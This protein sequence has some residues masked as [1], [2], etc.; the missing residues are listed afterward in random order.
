[1]LG[2]RVLV[3]AA[4][5]LATTSFAYKVAGQAH[6][7]ESF[8]A[9]GDG[10][11]AQG[12]PPTLVGR[13]WIFRNQSNPIGVS[14]YW[15]EFG[16]EWGHSGSALGHGGFSFWQ[17]NTSRLSAWI[18]LPAIPNQ[19][20]GDPL[21]FWTSAPTN[22][23]GT[24]NCSLEVRYSPSGGTSTGSGPTGIG[25]FTQLLATI[26]GTG[27]HA[28]TE[29][30]Y[31]LPGSGRIAI[32]M[33]LGPYPMSFP[34]TGSF[35]I[36]TLRVGNPPPPPYPIPQ[37]GETVR[38]TISHSPVALTRDATGQ[39][40]RIPAGATLIVDPGV[41]VRI[42]S[43]TQ[44]EIAGSVQLTGSMGQNVLIRGTGSVRVLRDGLLTGTFAD[45]QSFTDLVYGA[46][47]SF[48]DSAFSD[49]SHPT[50]F[51]YDSAGDIGHRF[52]DGNLD[53]ARQVLS[54][55]GCTFGQGCEVS[56]LRGWL[57]ARDCTFTRGGVVSAMPGPTG[58]E[59]MFVVGNSILDNITVNEAYIDLTHDHSQYRYIGNINVNGN[60]DG[61]GIRLAGGGNYLI[62]EDVVLTGHR[63]PVQFGSNSAGILPGSVLPA[64]GNQLN[65]IPTGLDA[66]PIDERVFWADTGLPYV[67]AR[68]GALR[69]QITILPGVTVKLLPDA[70]FFFDTDSNGAAMPI[71][72]GEPERPIRFEPYI[73]GTQWYSLPIGT[74]SVFGTRWDWCE[75]EGARFGVGTTSMPLAL[76]NCSFIDNT[77]AIYS[78]SIVSLR[79]CTFE[80]NVFSYT[81]ERFAPLHTVQGFLDANHPAN[82]NTFVSNNGDPAPDFFG[83]FLPNGGLIARA[84]HNSLEN[85]DSDVRNNWWGTPTG[86]HEARNP[87]GTGDAVHFGIDVGG[88]LLPFMTEP[89]TTNP[90]PVVRYLTERT[91]VVPGERIHVQWTAR[92]DGT[93]ATQRVYYSPDSNADDSMQFHAEVPPTARSFEWTVPTIGTPANGADQFFRVVATDD[94]GQEG[95]ADIALKISN[96]APFTGSMTP[97]TTI[98]SILR[99]G[100][101]QPACASVAGTLGSIYASIEL[102]NDDSGTSLGGA[103]ITAGQACT[104]LPAQ[105][106]DAS[107]DR[108]RIRFDATASLNQV[109][110]YY[111]PYFSIRP[112][113]IL[114]DAA[115]EVSLTSSHG[116]HTYAGGSVVEV[117]WT[118]SDDEA[119][120]GFDIRASY[121]GGTRWFVVARGLPA[122]AR[123]FAW[124]L[125][126]SSGVP[127]ANVRVVAKDVRFQNTSAESG[128]FAIS[129]GDWPMPCT[130]DFNA[131]GAAN[132]QDFFDF[133]S[134]FFA[135]C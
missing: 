22:A 50:T 120:R 38:W 28:W 41:E 103:F 101:S 15:T 26:P 56:L 77:R 29:R 104:V 127:R 46:R 60:P 79:K 115:P 2:Q 74:T 11:G 19:I 93:I 128:A 52:F 45:V 87:G 58:G 109:R 62:N 67:V 121:D 12:G 117:A 9:I 64:T 84:R 135:G 114:G 47:A 73:P 70:V 40:P 61:P 85:T 6:F 83:S 119:L 25:S 21:N 78:E 5:C 39:N 72:L 68:D 17:N 88:F 82:P 75:F 102:D 105:I 18:V 124:Q 96:P 10:N 54:L 81:G 98:P 122:D 107:T 123:S 4:G 106:P 134:L 53:Y 1:M 65:E 76:D 3:I 126:A 71:F 20:T 86:P 80:N 113:P 112:D 37:S 66:A 23:F 27:G 32:R 95:I 108:A 57:A 35:L 99:P 97:S 89:P 55:T 116:G 8:A 110:S 30:T 34:F 94:L 7:A 111:G 118:A 100:E 59:A 36:D 48:A 42:A 14:P 91:T 24:N 16:A 43:G 33:M 131:D 49:P 92:D 13:G 125:P 31:A 132:S 51:S 129:A 63:W 133:V 69:G 130:A 90:P 44:F